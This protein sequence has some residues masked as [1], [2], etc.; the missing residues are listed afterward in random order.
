MYRMICCTVASLLLL[1]APLSA[2]EPMSVL[3]VTG[4]DYKCHKW[5]ETAPLVK[6][7]L[8]A[9]G[10]CKVTQVEDYTPLADADELAKYD[11]VVLHIK[12]DGP[13]QNAA[14]VK[15]H[16]TEYVEGGGG[17]VLI[18][19]ACGAFEDWP[20]FKKLAGRVWDKKK[21]AHDPR[22]E[23][24][25]QV[26]DKKHPIMRDI[27]EFTVLDELYTCLGDEGPEIKVILTATSKVD[28]KV[29]PMAFIHHVGKGRVF[30]TVLGHDTISLG[31]PSV[32]KLLRQATVWTAT[33]SE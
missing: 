14:E 18:H 3:L 11:V 5:Q 25:C 31:T 32:K 15:K 8:E 7:T 23:F 26:A 29:Y 10:L 16:F 33:S 20:E 2:E 1:G 27:E 13:M 9:D 19:F 24:T 6:A 28:K 21:R 30:N 12:N 17:L 22:G 4:E